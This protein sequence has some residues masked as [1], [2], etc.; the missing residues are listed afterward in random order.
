MNEDSCNLESPFKAPGKLF[1]SPLTT[2]NKY[3]FRNKVI[4]AKFYINIHFSSAYLKI[5]NFYD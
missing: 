5:D 2:D 3:V 4:A 1:V